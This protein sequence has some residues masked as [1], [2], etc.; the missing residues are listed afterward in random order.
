MNW[1][2]VTF[3]T[4]L[5]TEL[6]IPNSV[7]SK[8]KIVNFNRP[9]GHRVD[10]IKVHIEIDASVDLVKACMLEAARNCSKIL[11]TPAPLAH[12]YEFT[13]RGVI[14]RLR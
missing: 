6:T 4:E 13:P 5:E 7:V 14:Y 8:S 1:R 9:N 2:V 11:Q 3:E 12:V 10:L